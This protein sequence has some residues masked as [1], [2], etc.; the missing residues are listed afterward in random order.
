MATLIALSRVLKNE[1]WCKAALDLVAPEAIK[2]AP[3]P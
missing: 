3:D 2:E 1:L